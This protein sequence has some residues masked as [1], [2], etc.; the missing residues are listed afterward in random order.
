MKCRPSFA[1]TLAATLLLGGCVSIPLPPMDGEKTKAGDWGFIKVMVTYVPNV[2]NLVNAY[3]E[4]KK[5]E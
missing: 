1:I 2:G 3:K 4:W 5:P